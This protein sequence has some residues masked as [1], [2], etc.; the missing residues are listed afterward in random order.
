MEK[1]ELSKINNNPSDLEHLDKG[2]EEVIDAVVNQSIGSHNNVD[3]FI[4]KGHF[5]VSIHCRYKSIMWL[6]EAF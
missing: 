3:P 2:A 5:G 6:M 1:H 4:L